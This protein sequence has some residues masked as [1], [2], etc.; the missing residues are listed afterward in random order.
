MDLI[1]VDDVDTQPGQAGVDGSFEMSA[2]GPAIG[3]VTAH[4]EAGLGGDGEP[5]CA[6]PGGQPPSDDLLG[7][8]PGVDVGGVDERA[9]LLD[10]TIKDCV[11]RGFVGL[12]PEGHGSEAED[13]QF[14]AGLSE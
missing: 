6:A 3:R 13:A 10:E 7:G 12:G 14:Q 9:A 2:A 11:R 4:R 8:A 1:E 5:V